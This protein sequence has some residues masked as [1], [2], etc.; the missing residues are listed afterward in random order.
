MDQ[1]REVINKQDVIDQ[2]LLNEH[3]I[4]ILIERQG[5][6]LDLSPIAQRRLAAWM[7]VVLSQLARERPVATF[8]QASIVLHCPC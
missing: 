4:P 3:L 5:R 2:R 1:A 8:E 6:G 7:R